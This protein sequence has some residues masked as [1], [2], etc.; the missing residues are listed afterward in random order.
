M[1]PRKLNTKEGQVSRGE[2]E[3]QFPTCGL[4]G[5]EEMAAM[6]AGKKKSAK[7]LRLSVVSASV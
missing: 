2:A 7:I 5:E 3:K 4:A 6:E 1:Q